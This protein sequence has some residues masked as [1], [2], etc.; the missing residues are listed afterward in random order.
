MD[1]NEKM[2]KVI[3]YR[4]IQMLYSCMEVVIIVI[5][6]IAIFII[7]GVMSKKMASLVCERV[8]IPVNTEE[9]YW[10]V[11]VWCIKEE[12]VYWRKEK[13]WRKG[14]CMKFNRL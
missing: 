14:K 6:I 2:E 8:I 12:C 11:T 4:D 10:V 7:G 13:W 5:I 9:K 3:A 1:G